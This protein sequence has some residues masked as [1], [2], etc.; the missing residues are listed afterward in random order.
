MNVG[1]TIAQLQAAA[2]EIERAREEAPLLVVVSRVNIWPKWA[3]LSC[4]TLA[5]D[6]RANR[7]KTDDDAVALL[8]SGRPYRHNNPI[9]CFVLNALSA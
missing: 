1:R 9:W 3:N 2:E 4:N 5:Q 7:E 6:Y 8:V